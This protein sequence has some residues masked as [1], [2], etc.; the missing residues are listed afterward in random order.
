MELNAEEKESC[1]T[2][3]QTECG[4]EFCE[5]RKLKFTKT[6]KTHSLQ[7]PISLISFLWAHEGLTWTLH[8][9][10]K[11]ERFWLINM[12]DFLIILWI[13]I[14]KRWQLLPALSISHFHLTCFYEHLHI[15]KK[16][17]I[18]KTTTAFTLGWGGKVGTDKSAT[19]CSGNR[20]I[21][22]SR[23]DACDLNIKLIYETNRNAVFPSFPTWFSTV[24]GLTSA[25]WIMLFRFFFCRGLMTD[26]R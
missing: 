25:L 16:W 21:N 10:L 8:F 15:K 22:H 14:K 20:R 19:Q 1:F 13:W 2:Y 23:R 9:L 24:W 11:F 7:K 12:R 6:L 4:C 5:F 26:L 3:Q 18:A 17:N